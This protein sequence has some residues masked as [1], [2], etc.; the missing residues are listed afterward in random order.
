MAEP[1]PGPE[2]SGGAS[3][4]QLLI[5]ALTSPR[6][7]FEAIARQPRFALT[8]VVLVVISLATVQVS[9]RK[10]P[11]TDF[12]HQIEESGR[13][14]PPQLRDDPE[15]MLRITL[16]TQTIGTV[17]LMPAIYLG[18]AGI[19]LVILRMMGSDLTFRQSLATNVHGVLPLAVMGLVTIA[20]ALGRSEVSLLDLQSGGLAPSHL[21]LLAGEDTSKA[22]RALLSS[23][24]VFSAWAVFLLATG[25]RIVA[26]VSKGVAWGVVAGVWSVGI[27]IKVGLALAF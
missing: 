19:F 15:K 17:L 13:E 8:M 12:I 2:P 9:M 5:Q 6:A 10:I 1:V 24:D 11:P 20:I 16:W 23:I 25:Y 4:L 27:L 3:S 7:A 18:V 26:R 22:M 21:G 14:V